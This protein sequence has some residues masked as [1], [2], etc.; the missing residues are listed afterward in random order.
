MRYA[1]AD[2]QLVSHIGETIASCK[3]ERLLQTIA[4]FD[5]AGSTAAKVQLGHERG[6]ESSLKAVLLFREVVGHHGGYTVKELGD[7][8]LARFDDPLNAA[9]AGLDILSLGADLAIP[10]KGALTLGLVDLLEIEGGPLDV[11]GSTV[12]RCC[13]IECFCLPGQ[14][15]VDRP[16]LDATRSFLRD[17][18]NVAIGESKARHLKGL[19]DTELFE[20]ADSNVGLK[21]Y[22][23]TDFRVHEEGRMP[24][25]DK[26]NF[27]KDA[28][29]E[30]VEIGTGLR[31][32]SRYFS[33]QRPAE[34]RKYVE[35]LVVKG[36]NVTILALDPDW[37]GTP[38]YLADRS[39]PDYKDDISRSLRDLRA[40][41]RRLL[42]LGAQGRFEIRLYRSYP[43]GHILCA[44]PD[45]DL[46]GRMF[47]SYYLPGLSRAEC[48][49]FEF[50]W[51]SNRELFLKH[52]AALKDVLNNRSHPI[53]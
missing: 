38:L 33:G 15:L 39:E 36:V 1:P 8:I 9:L 28:S 30:V 48:P 47:V 29:A 18:D 42:G 51:L 50:S 14:L 35:N 24:L 16:Y 31:T 53:D 22:I 4:F 23:Y 34:F 5:L 17:F 44:D 41:R 2:P 11:L 45:D 10:V 21:K 43:F 12:D 25:H 52:R 26:V 13:R 32:F 40:E 6:L 3:H 20:I 27:V 7:G 37:E 19:G 49:V 46:F